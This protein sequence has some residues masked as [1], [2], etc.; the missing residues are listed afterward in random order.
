MSDLVTNDPGLSVYF[1]IEVDGVD[2]G[3]WTTCSGLSISIS[4]ESRTD[5]AMSFVMHH[6]PGHVSF[7]N[8]TLGRPI[9]P[10]TEKVVNW[11][12]AFAMMPVPTAAQIKAM[13]P[14]GGIIMTWNLFGVIPVKWTGPDFDASSLKIAE[15]KLELA[16]K[17]FL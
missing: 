16:F 12:S 2:L 5:T 8:I 17:G 11:V 14:A 3:D 9:S 6:L 1:G 4:A 13:D 10:D 7:G 15:E